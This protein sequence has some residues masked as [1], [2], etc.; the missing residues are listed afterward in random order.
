[1]SQSPPVKVK[2][3]RS[4]ISNIYIIEAEG[5]L[6]AVDAGSRA[7]GLKSF[8]R[9]IKAMN[10]DPMSV[11]LL[12]LTH[13]HYDHVKA[14]AAISR[15]CGCPVAVHAAEAEPLAAGVMVVPPGS[16]WWGRV[17]SGLGR[18]A[19]GRA[20]VPVVMGHEPVQAEVKVGTE[21]RLDDY[22][23]AGALAPTPGHS[24]GSMSLVLDSGQAFVGDL[25]FNGYPFGLS[26]I[27]PPFAHDVPRLL[28]SWRHLLSRGVKVFYPGH[29]K[30]ITAE[31]LSRAYLKYA[32]A[33]GT[34]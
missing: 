12:V 25:I 16:N 20:L 19:L 5:G 1:M 33:V 14:A 28:Q 6:V 13:V 27:M 21:M 29:G 2:A 23:L 18:S 11:R 3:L 10:L 4:G 31:T 15:A 26:P 8:E 22:G 30:A 7:S 24:P 32:E 17:A 34:G 9:T